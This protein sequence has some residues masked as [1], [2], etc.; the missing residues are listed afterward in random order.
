MELL[1]AI[2]PFASWLLVPL[3]IILGVLGEHQGKRKVDQEQKTSA[4]NSDVTKHKDIDAYSKK[5][6]RFYFGAALSLS[7]F[8][9]ATYLYLKS[10]KSRILE[11]ITVQGVIYVLIPLVVLY[12]LIF[13]S[14]NYFKK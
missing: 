10:T 13:S 14:Q 2:R 6:A 7:I 8:T 1:E 5:R 11:D 4:F 3:V 12:L 9:L